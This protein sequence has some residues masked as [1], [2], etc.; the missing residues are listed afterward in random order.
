MSKSPP[1]FPS[2]TMNRI[3]STTNIHRG[4]NTG[5]LEKYQEKYEVQTPNRFPK[6][7]KLLAEYSNRGSNKKFPDYNPEKKPEEKFVPSKSPLRNTAYK[8]KETKT[9]C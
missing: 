3:H 8:K 7:S 9:G 6:P 4:K 2:L 5:N 1:G